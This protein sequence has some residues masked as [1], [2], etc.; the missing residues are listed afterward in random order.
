M[1]LPRPGQQMVSQLWLESG[2][3]RALLVLFVFALSGCGGLRLYS[4]TRDKQ[5]QA[6]AKAWSEVD[7][8]AFFAAE[9]DNDVKLLE[10]E[11][12]TSARRIAADRDVTIR[13]LARRPVNAFPD[14]Y[15]DRLVK[16]IG[17]DAPIADRAA[18]E[19][20]IREAHD[21]SRA[22]VRW[23]D[24]LDRDYSFLAQ[25]DVPRFACDDLMQPD[26]GAVSAW[27][28]EHPDD[29]KKAKA[30]L[31]AA[32]DKCERVAASKKSYRD[33]LKRLAGG[34]LP[35]LVSE[36]EKTEAEFAMDQAALRKH[37]GQYAAALAQYKAEVAKKDPG[38]SSKEQLAE[39][40]GKVESALKAI[41][42]MPDSFRD[43]F[44]AE[45][46]IKAIN[47]LLADLKAGDAPG[48][49]AS[50]IEVA[51]LLLPQLADDVRAVAGAGKGAG[52]VPLLIKRDVEQARLNAA[53]LQLTTSEHRIA[54]RSAAVES[55]LAEAHYI[56]RARAMF[57]GAPTKATGLDK[58][59]KPF[60]E[61]W[62][63]LTTQQKFAL[64]DSVGLYLDAVGRQR[65][66]TERL[67]RTQ[68]ALSKKQASGLS[69][70]NAG[71]WSSLIGATVGQAAEFA[72]TGFKASDFE[73]ILSTIGIVWIGYGVNK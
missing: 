50:K 25:M 43:K 29:A 7:L 6:A 1:K 65:A 71:M 57:L 11:I 10:Q 3:C 68:Y 33:A 60:H 67:Q 32:K 9:R 58:V 39:L 23:G 8:K 18:V 35:K 51:V 46:R 24:A 59:N 64:L 19:K 4:E 48:P 5:G 55:A 26:Q 72:A 62:S 17:G 66:F 49:D 54:L 40:A 61:A 38:R 47:D 45:E 31:G 44:I 41:E 14:Y 16:L 52:V 56:S 27:A 69:E 37:Q 20:S 21:A 70:I 12:A 42:A 73:G 22:I 30:R 34:E 15:D 28:A 2:R 13:D 53:Q 36:L 63:G